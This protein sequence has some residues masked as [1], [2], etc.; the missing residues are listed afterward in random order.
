MPRSSAARTSAARSRASLL[1]DDVER[2]SVLCR[3][4]A[5]RDA[6]D[7][8]LAIRPRAEVGELGVAATD[9]T[10]GTAFIDVDLD[11]YEDLV[12]LNGHR[13][14]VRDADT[15]E[16][17]RNSHVPWNMEQDEFPRLA[18]RRVVMR[19]RGDL[20]FADVS[21]AWG[22]ET[23]PAIWR[24]SRSPTSTEMAHSTWW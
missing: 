5:D 15:F 4:R 22:V 8:E 23:E 18:V 6:A 2:G 11:G 16:R 14:D 21:Q 13:W 19:N 1:V 10:W 17:I 12:A 3:Q 9:W 7:R 20:T 24:G